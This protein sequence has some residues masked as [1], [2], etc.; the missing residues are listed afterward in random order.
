MVMDVFLQIDIGGCGSGAS[1]E[2]QAPGSFLIIFRKEVATLLALLL[3]AEDKPRL[4]VQVVVNQR[5]FLF[6]DLDLVWIHHCY[7]IRARMREPN[8]A[9]IIVPFWH[10]RILAPSHIR[11]LTFWHS[12]IIALS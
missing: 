12:G 7:L 1:E 2:F 5:P 10:I 6:S 11:I 9:T 3:L 4:H 8:K